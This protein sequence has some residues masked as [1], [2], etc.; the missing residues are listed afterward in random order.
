VREIRR[1]D[2]RERQES[3][4]VRKDPLTIYAFEHETWPAI[5]LL[6]D[7]TI[8]GRIKHR[9]R[10]QLTALLGRERVQ[11]LEALSEAPEAEVPIREIGLR[12]GESRVLDDPMDALVD[13]M[14]QD[15]TVPSAQ[16]VLRE[17]DHIIRA[18]S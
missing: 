2:Q 6:D 9:V 18:L 1:R 16:A 13:R 12:L 17:L 11:F 3:Y 4:V 14:T 8:S 7:P 15:D 5:A 10:A